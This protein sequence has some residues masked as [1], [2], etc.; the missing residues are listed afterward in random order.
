MG[1]VAL[2]GNDSA[3][4]LD[5]SSGALDSFRWG[6][7]IL[8]TY[9]WIWFSVSLL[10]FLVWAGYLWIQEQVSPPVPLSYVSTTRLVVTPP[11]DTEDVGGDGSLR[12]WLS[13]E[14]LLRQLILSEEVLTRVVKKDFPS[15]AWRDLR[16]QIE[17]DSLGET[18]DSSFLLEI[19]AVSDSPEKSM[20][21][22]QAL[23]REFMGYTQELAAREV[24]AARVL[25]EK[26][27]HRAKEDMERAQEAIVEWRRKHNAWDVE[28]LVAD[29]AKRVEEA[30]DKLSQV[31]A[32]LVETRQEV[33]DLERFL[34]DSSDG[35]PWAIV[36][37]ED[38]ELVRL[39][40]D[41][42]SVR[43]RWNKVKDVYTEHSLVYQKAKA[44]FVKARSAYLAKR[45]A[46][47]IA[48]L[49][50][51][52]R[53]LSRLEGEEAVLRGRLKAVDNSKALA[54]QQ[55]ELE[56]LERKLQAC[57]NN[58]DALMDQINNA[59]VMEQRRRHLA[60]FTVVDKALPGV[61]VS[62]LP[63]DQP[64]SVK[65][66]VALLGSVVLGAALILLLDYLR[67]GLRLKPKVEEALGVPVLGMIPK[68]SED[69]ARGWAIATG[70][71]PGGSGRSSRTGARGV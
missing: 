50:E 56:Q 42:A 70:N 6:W 53:K 68:L 29:Y 62:D 33:S 13:N 28:S 22:A 71:S 24:I 63:A 65:L 30:K 3:S 27:A 41:Y 9:R 44:E 45:K 35:V 46:L 25:L 57:Q 36:R 39:Q 37:L 18:G 19:K 40:A 54:A 10:V 26:M 32:E 8:A 69:Y 21:L 31:R 38:P 1:S 67:A 34:S 52:R 7:R 4:Y 66:V 20:R 43:E 51:K 64:W 5:S 14:T 61:P 49:N 11:S 58:Y 48:L 60:A 59:R 47:V 16:E 15:V 2:V 23:V 55:V 17:V 12:S